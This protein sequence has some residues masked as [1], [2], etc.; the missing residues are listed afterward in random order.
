M[1]NHQLE[2]LI[3]TAMKKVGAKK[4]NDICRYIPASD[5]GYVHHFS[6]KK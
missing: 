5:E 2:H 6:F 1:D 3:A 4:E